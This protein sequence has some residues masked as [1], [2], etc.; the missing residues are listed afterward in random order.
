MPETPGASL[1]D[2]VAVS[3]SPVIGDPTL[4]GWVTVGIYGLAA[5]VICRV[6][7][8]ERGRDRMLWLGTAVLL[9]LLMV[10]KQLDLQ[11]ALTAIGRCH[12]EIYGWYEDRRKVQLAAILIVGVMAVLIMAV[13]V[14]LYRD[15][16][17]RHLLLLCSICGLLAFIAIR[18]AG[19][20]HFDQIIGLQLGIFRLNHVLELGAL[21]LFLV[22][23][24]QRRKAH[25]LEDIYGPPPSRG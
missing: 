14:L 13:L 16:L 17:G 12:A 1:F 6:G 8:A 18:L 20:H 11:S 23:G 24:W 22:A 9:L 2:C 19:F 7:L 25:R 3:W 4:L 10:N 21:S 15:R 5:L